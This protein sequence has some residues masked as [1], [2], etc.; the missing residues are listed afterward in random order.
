MISQEISRRLHEYLKDVRNKEIKEFLEKPTLIKEDVTVSRIIGMMTKE[1]A[2][3][4]FIQLKDKSITCINIRDILSSRNIST[5]KS[6]RERGRNPTVTE[7]DTIGNAARV[8]NLYRLRSLPVIN[9]NNHDIIGQISSKR[10]IKYIYDTFSGKKIDF[11][12]M[13]T[14]SDIMTPDLI[15]IDPKDKFDSAKAIM[16]RDLIDHL[17]VAERYS[18]GKIMIKGMITS[19][20]IMQT[21]I[22]AESIG[23]RSLGT[24]DDLKSEQEVIGIADKNVITVDPDDTIMSTIDTLFKANSTY[25]IVKSVDNVLGIITYRDIISLLGEQIQSDVPIYIIGMPEDP[26]E[27]EL[28]RSK[29]V[30]IVKHL[31][32]MSPKIEEARCKIKIRDI[33]G[34]RKRYEVSASI[35]TTYRRHGYTSNKG[36]DLAKIFDEMSDGLKNQV[37]HEKSERQEKSVRHSYE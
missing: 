3:E 28:V 11:K 26:F 7:N 12:K 8:M 19:N 21:L 34:E 2:H 27:A 22:P 36:W 37:A 16:R 18:D 15:I 35:N 13:I 17:P 6:S 31:S 25:T 23:R 14:A 32:R 1:N 4:I 30:N 10:I 33:E 9:Q 20:H 5:V 24:E 29:F